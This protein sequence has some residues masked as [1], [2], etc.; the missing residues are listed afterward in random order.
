MVLLG[1]MAFNEDCKR[2]HGRGHSAHT[3]AH[4]QDDEAKTPNYVLRY[5]LQG[6]KKAI[7]SVK[8]SP[9][10]K[11]LASACTRCRDVPVMVHGLTCARAPY[12]AADKQIKLWDAMDGQ[13]KA[14]LT[15]HSQGISD[16]AWSDDSAYLAS[17][18]DDKT[19]RVWDIEKVRWRLPMALCR[20]RRA[21]RCSAQVGTNA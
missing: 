8:F 1:M 5:T 15:G 2:A 3:N 19:V 16:V 10:G 21:A 6:H 14:T 7:S 18:S 20:S 9:D 12:S 4:A 17:A 11:L 13:Y